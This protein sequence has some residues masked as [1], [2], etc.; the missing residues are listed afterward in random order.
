MK[1]ERY[2]NWLQTRLGFFVLLVSLIWAKSLF[3][4]HVDF[5]LGIEDRLQYFILLINP[6]ATTIFLLATALYIKKTKRSYIVM[7]L[8]YSALSL[9]LFCNI[10][11]YREFTDFMTIN[12]ILGAGKV[13]SGLGESALGLLR[14]Y[15]FLYLLD[16]PLLALLL[17]TKRLTMNPTPIRLRWSMAITALA[18]L[19]FW[20]NLQLAESSRYGLLQRTFSSSHI[21][22]YLG[23]NVFTVYDGIQTY[24]ANQNRAQASEND[25]VGIKE[26]VTAHHAK[27]N[28]ETFGIAANR[29]VIYIHLESLQQFVIDYKLKDQQGIEHEVTP[30]LNSLFH[31][32]ETFSFENI[33]HQVNAGKTSDAETLLENSFFGLEQ[34]PLFTQLGDKNTFQAAPAILNQVAGYTSAVFHGNAGSF[35]NRN[36]T[37]KRFGYDYFFDA[38]SYDV[39]KSNSFQYGLHDKPFFQQ[40]V[41]YLEH[42]QQPFYTKMIAVSN[43]YPYATFDDGDGGFPLAHTKDTTINGYFAT[44]NYLDK[45]VE[46]CFNYLKASGLYEKSLIVLYGDHY[47]ISDSRNTDLAELLGK[48]PMQ[49][50]NF[51][52]AQ[53]QR[54]PLMFHLPGRSDG[55]VDTTYG[56]QV[57]VL[58]T[59]LSLLGIDSSPYLQL[60]QDLLSKE[61]EQLVAFRNGNFVTPAYT[62]LGENIYL[63]QTGQLVLDPGEEL[64]QN[65]SHL[66]QKVQRQL[67]ASDLMTNGD[68]LR[69]YDNGLKEVVPEEYRYKNQLQQ[70]E[71]IETALGTNSTS[72]FSQNG[73]HSTI[74]LYETKSYQDYHSD[75]P[76]EVTSSSS[77][78]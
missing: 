12:T 73:Q 52:N 5:N 57:D 46:E 31:G 8:L 22:K 62:V 25:V 77:H 54:V 41:Q 36:E 3:A 72:L 53:M 26:Y 43:H 58:P 4:Y 75:Q 47:G 61:N 51:D 68:L 10:L 15:D 2:L 17:A 14:L 40:S 9:L 56:G 49:W 63:N 45:A 29:N 69:Y 76:A 32:A 50:G 42:L 39:T 18:C 35:W 20:G 1:K 16:I 13:A 23:I 70:L 78:K 27:A 67:A 19:L 38:K 30:F 34:G 71:A 64:T 33:F 55:G 7:M 66:R 48:A 24:Q 37:Y 28:P 60:G 65:V 11:Y 21:V 44:A 6:F 59:L 74:D